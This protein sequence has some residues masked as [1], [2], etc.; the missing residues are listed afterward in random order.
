MGDDN[1]CCGRKVRS[2]VDI[3][4]MT[5]AAVVF[6][7]IVRRRILTVKSVSP[8]AH[9]ISVFFFG[10]GGGEGKKLLSIKCRATLRRQKKKHFD[11]NSPPS[12]L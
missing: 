5:V 4:T 7:A 2:L 8:L 1:N 6:Y 11:G 9:F 3:I 12:L 10:G